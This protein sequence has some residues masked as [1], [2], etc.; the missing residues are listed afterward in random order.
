[1]NKSVLLLK[2]KEIGIKGVSSKTKNEIL[3]LIEEHEQKKEQLNSNITENKLTI[4]FVLKVLF[5]IITNT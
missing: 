4:N 5:Y 1:M 2:C 3:L